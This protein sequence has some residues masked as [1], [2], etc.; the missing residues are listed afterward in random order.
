LEIKGWQGV[1][2]VNSQITSLLHNSTLAQPLLPAE[3]IKFL[4]VIQIDLLW[5]D[6]STSSSGAEILVDCCHAP[7]HY[8]VAKL[9]CV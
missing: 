3:E 1:G 4:F 5:E 9:M 2:T 6:M 8:W 7:F